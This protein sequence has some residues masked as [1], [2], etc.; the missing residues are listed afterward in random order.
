MVPKGSV[1]GIDFGTTNSTIARCID[2]S[3]K[4][5]IVRFPLFGGET[6][7]Y[8][9]LLYLERLRQDGKN[10]LISWTQLWAERYDREMQDTSTFRTKSLKPSWPN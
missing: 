6:E 3:S 7:S 2:P 1:V 4:V 8:R 9:S 10:R 5:E